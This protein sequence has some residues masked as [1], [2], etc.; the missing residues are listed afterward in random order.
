MGEAENRKIF[1]IQNEKYYGNFLLNFLMR[2]KPVVE[3]STEG[4]VKALVIEILSGQYKRI[5]DT[6][7]IIV[8]TVLNHGGKPTSWIDIYIY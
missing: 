8:N 4:V 3:I 5:V 7:E 6:G 1:K 2:G